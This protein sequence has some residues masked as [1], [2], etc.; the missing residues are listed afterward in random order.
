MTDTYRSIAEDAIA[1]LASE[2]G[3]TEQEFGIGKA[4][5]NYYEK[6]QALSDR[7]KQLDEGRA[8]KAE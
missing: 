8:A 3:I 4:S 5:E 1:A 2:E 7:L 6:S